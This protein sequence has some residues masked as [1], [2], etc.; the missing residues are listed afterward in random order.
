MENTFEAGLQ[1]SGRPVFGT[2]F[3]TG[4]SSGI[5]RALCLELAK[6]GTHVV[7]AA[8]RQEKLNSLVEEIRASGGKADACLLDVRD[9]QAV[10]RV[11]GEQ[12]RAVGGFD[13]VIA[14]AGVASTGPED[15]MTWG[16]AEN[17]IA[18]NFTAAISTLIEAKE[19]M[20]PRGRGTLAAISSLA[21]LRA[22]PGSGAYCATK[23]GLQTFLE[24][25]EL[26]L[27]GTGL[28]VADIQPGFVRSEMTDSNAS[29]MPF[30]W[31]VERAAKVCVAG[32]ERRNS[33]I[34]FPWQLSWPLRSVFKLLPR[35]WWRNLI[36]RS[37]P[38]SR[39]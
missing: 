17:V 24:T 31:E 25:M 35:R 7:G 29:P 36:T 27:A 13:I 16:E 5:G 34:S 37:R 3:V 8:R 32:L 4:A 1:V 9:S 26:D 6:R 21:G 2:A 39:S 18:V 28:E 22:M 23:A 33:V 12:D 14:N 10:H 11:M 19:L 30:F 38:Q 20:L 15:S